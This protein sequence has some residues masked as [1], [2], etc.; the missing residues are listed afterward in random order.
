MCKHVVTLSFCFFLSFLEYQI[1]LYIQEYLWAQLQ[2]ILI[3]LSTILFVNSLSIPSNASVTWLGV[4]L[5]IQK[6]RWVDIRQYFTA[7]YGDMISLL[8]FDIW[9][10][11]FRVCEITGCS[12][13]PRLRISTYPFKY[14]GW[15][16]PVILLIF[17]DSTPSINLRINFVDGFL[18]LLL[19]L[20]LFIST[21]R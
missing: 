7:S 5:G 12:G 21:F 6:S 16:S 9:S 15:D 2:I 11:D 17:M 18:W 1:G 8:S 13:C 10:I 14:P 3:V 20:I 4:V 19:V